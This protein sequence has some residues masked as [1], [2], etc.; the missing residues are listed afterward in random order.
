MLAKMNEMQKHNMSWIEVCLH[1]KQKVPF[2]HTQSETSK[3]AASLL[4]CSHQTLFRLD[5][6]KSATSCQQA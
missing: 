3:S 6:N 5:D 2:I 4:P 1:A